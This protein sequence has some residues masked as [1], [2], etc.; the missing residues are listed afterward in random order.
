MPLRTGEERIL[1]A[2]FAMTG[3][4][5]LEF[6]QWAFSDLRANNFRGIYAEWLVA[7]ILNLTHTPRA[8]WDDFD[9]KTPEGV[10]IEVKA[11]GYHQAWLQRAPSKIKFGNLKG[12]RL[13]IETNKYA[14][15]ASF[16][17]DLYIFCVHKE[18]NKDTADELDLQ[19][20]SFYIL[21]GSILARLN[22]KSL[23]LSTVADQ[24]PELSATELREQAWI[25]IRNIAD[26]QSSG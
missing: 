11:S 14:E 8:T 26:Q 3:D 5:I 6:W 2:P 10:K 7:R 4:T 18:E 9:L 21:P 17:A 16:N 23:S 13:D 1:N 20:W 24:T 19:Q 25:A 12:R 22:Q 15:S